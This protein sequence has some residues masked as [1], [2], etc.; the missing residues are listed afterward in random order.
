MKFL[1]KLI[2]KQPE[3]EKIDV[4][5]RFELIGRVGQG[6]MSK[7]WR[8]NDTIANNIVALK[9][10][11]RAKTKRLESRF[12]GMN[13]PVEGVIAMSLDHRNIVRTYEHGWTTNDEQYLIMEFV[14][15]VGLSFLVDVQN[16]TMKKRRLDFM[17]QL[18]NA[19]QYFHD[20][21]WIHRDICPRNVMVSDRNIV[22]LI[23]FGLV[24]PNTPEFRKPGNRTGTANYMAPE[25]IKRQRTDQ[26][27]DVFSY[28]VTC[29]E[30]FSRQLPWESG[31]TLE[32]VLQHINQPPT[33][34]RSI[35][36][37]ILEPVADTIMRGLQVRPD[38]RWSS[39]NDM[40]ERFEEVQED[41]IG[42]LQK[43]K[44]TKPTSKSDKRSSS[45]KRPTKREEA[46][47][48]RDPRMAKRATIDVKKKRSS[49]SKDE[50]KK[51]RAKQ[52]QSESTK[53][54]EKIADDDENSSGKKSRRSR[55]STSDKSDRRAERLARREARR[56]RQQEMAA[57]A[58]IK[59][60][61]PIGIS[62]DDDDSGEIEGIAIESEGDS[63]DDVMGG[64]GFEEDIEVEE[65]MELDGIE[66]EQ[67]GIEV[68]YSEDDDADAPISIDDGED[69]DE[70]EDEHISLE[71]D[72]DEAPIAQVQPTSEDEDLDDFM[73]SEED[74]DDDELM[75]GIEVE[76]D[77]EDDEDGYAGIEVEEDEDEDDDYLMDGIEIDE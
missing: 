16:D 33:D 51:Q 48:D 11:D 19:I 28:A 56:Q 10:L 50:A 54:H 39:V 74:D 58:E 14:E 46:E 68:D 26:R 21:N 35:V 42:G 61:E 5:K 64:I 49:S 23:D 62:L 15:G 41:G 17:I 4:T 27:L 6:S 71:D 31:E 3:I 37:N 59:D 72:E 65:D 29:Y 30:M 60:E 38:D 32:A 57:E 12:V 44:R 63:D 24:V 73:S 75:I 25:L 45:S 66:V 7:V 43:T 70:D 22:K 8:A 9:V 36:P 53:I 13:K 47:D 34:I 18:G 55:S 67:D 1:D 76:D 40:V 20:Q 2:N 52:R 77:E 69:D